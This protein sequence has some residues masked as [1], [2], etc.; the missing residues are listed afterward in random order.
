M[1]ARTVIIVT[2]GLILIASPPS[3]AQEIDMTAL[4]CADFVKGNRETI[5]SIMLWLSG[6]YT[7]EDDPP[8]ISL[9]RIS[10]KENQLKQYCADH[11]ALPLL[12]A[13]EIFMDKK[14][15]KDK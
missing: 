8:V 12:D 4:K 1:F 11:P 6:Y 14:Y 3:L 9:S 15:N 10:S 2:F 7:Y 13:S 5:T